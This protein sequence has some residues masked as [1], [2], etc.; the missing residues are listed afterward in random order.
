MTIIL[1][2]IFFLFFFIGVFI[3]LTNN[4]VHSIFGL[5]LLFFLAAGLAIIFGA[6]FLAFL[7]LIIYVGAVSVL[8]LF[9]VMLLNVRILD[10]TFNNMKYW[11]LGCLYFYSFFFSFSFVI[12][13]F[14]F[15]LTEFSFYIDFTQYLFNWDTTFQFGELLFVYFVN[16][17][18]FAVLILFLAVVSP[19]I[20]TFRSFTI[21]DNQGRVNIL[22]QKYSANS[23]Y[24]KTFLTN[25]YLINNNT[26]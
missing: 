24:K 4:P 17:L 6:E 11:W 9:I 12:N 14:V 23:P 2:F 19:V 13:R 18:F 3:I 8:F 15:L 5:I 26:L 10:M 21:F 1:N 25:I 22:L 20:L 16:L 7:I